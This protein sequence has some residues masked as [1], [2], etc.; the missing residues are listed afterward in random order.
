M[1]DPAPIETGRLI[2]ASN[3][4]PVVLAQDGTGGWSVEP[5]KGGLVNALTPVLHRRGGVWVGWPGTTS[6]RLI[7]GD[8]DL[9]TLL[10]PVADEIGYDLEPVMMTDRERED[11]YQGFCNEI[12]WPLFH[13]LQSRA[14]FEPTYFEAY[15]RLNQRY[16]SRIADIV[17]PEDFIWI[18]D[19]HLLDAAFE[20]RALG[21]ENRLGFFL[22]IPFPPLDIFLKLPWRVELLRALLDFDLVGFQTA[23]D[24]RNF[25]MCVRALLTGVEIYEDGDLYLLTKG[26]SH[27][28]VVGA[29]PISMDAAE[30]RRRA[31]AP[32]TTAACERL[33]GELGDRALLLGVDRLDY[34]KGIPHRL[35]AYRMALR[36]YPELRRRVT[37]I[38]VVVP[39]RIE[40]PEYH[41]LKV[42]LDQ[43]VGEINGEFTE[44]GWAPIHYIF[45]AVEFTELLALYRLARIALV[46]PLKDGMNLV[47]KE[48]CVSRLA[49]DGVLVLS[50]FAGAAAQL[51]RDALLVN[52]FNIEEVAEAIH[53]AWAMP[54][55]ERHRR[56]SELQRLVLDQDIYWWLDKFLE[57]ARR[58]ERP[59]DGLDPLC[60]DCGLLDEGRPL[61]VPAD[62]P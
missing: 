7:E 37:L 17:R 24:R 45:R 20:L 35:E 55:D 5:G 50:E 57:A 46:T 16:A 6:E 13:D 54:E 47:S 2:I 31:Q 15:R 26:G 52:P 25:V 43:L 29:F 4:L 9:E 3:R 18:Q 62:T 28:T 33:R 58:A 19:Y 38:Q 22:H 30:F 49:P 21:V 40:I 36:R 61:Q 1:A 27:R 11:F 44:P 34:T 10:G 14:H 23:R 56:M 8:A 60:A 32:E 39:S 12:I 53:R 41:D 48:F 42:E 59:L 51:G